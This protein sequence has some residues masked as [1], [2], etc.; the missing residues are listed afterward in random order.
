MISTDQVTALAPDAASFKAGKGLA[1]ASKWSGL[2]RSD[3][4]LWG[5]AKGSGS[6]PYQ[7]QVSTED[8]TTKCSCPSRKFPCKHALGL[9]FIAAQDL[10]QIVEA[11]LPDWVQAWKDSQQQRQEKQQKK[12]TA[13]KPKN[14]ETAARSKEKRGARVNEGIKFLDDFLVDLIRQGLAQD[15]VSDAA[16]WDT[17][18]RRLIDCQAPGLASYVRRLADVPYSGVHWESR[19]LHEMGALHLLLHTYQQRD[20]L[21]PA[22]CAEVEQRI[23]WQLEKEKVL[24]GIPVNDDWFVAF[25]TVI[26]SNKLRVFSSW[27]FGKHNKQW[28]LLLSFS[29]AGSVPDVLWP[30]GSTVSTELAFYPGITHERALPIDSNA[31]VN[32][33]AAIDAVPETVDQ[34]LHRVVQSMAEN[35]WCTRFSFLLCAQPAKVGEQSVLVDS[36]GNAVAWQCS[37]EQQLILETVCGGRPILL[38]GEWDG[39][40]SRVH[41]ANDNGVWFQLGSTTQ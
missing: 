29:T 31:A 22:M 25:R 38:A 39:R 23:G 21:S 1:V 28:A 10:T 33:R 18:A 5:L 9:M 15:T 6:K 30:V 40:S 32:T 34:L 41:A 14:T 27:L 17:V 4:L 37:A 24:S 35:P 8:F 11:P 3:N 13:A 20:S 12:K 36:L 19:L 16:G 7:A 2:G 26:D